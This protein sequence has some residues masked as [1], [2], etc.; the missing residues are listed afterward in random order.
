MGEANVMENVVHGAATNEVECLWEKGVS[1][2]KTGTDRTKVGQKSSVLNNGVRRWRVSNGTWNGALDLASPGTGGGAGGVG[3]MVESVRG[4]VIL[5]FE[6]A[7]G[8]NGRFLSPLY[9]L[10]VFSLLNDGAYGLNC[11]HRRRKPADG[12]SN[13]AHSV[14][15]R[16][17]LTGE[18]LLVR[19]RVSGAENVGCEIACGR[20]FERTGNKCRGLGPFDLFKHF[21]RCGGVA[22]INNNTTAGAWVTKMDDVNIGGGQTPGNT[23]VRDMQCMVPG[24]P[25]DCNCEGPVIGGAGDDGDKDRGD[26][27]GQ[28][29]FYPCLLYTSPSPRDRQKSRMPSSA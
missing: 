15:F 6:I 13:D 17:L 9:C 2:R 16:P 14:F 1:A 26:K 4:C 5:T 3:V 22:K 23:V 11:I 20:T 29:K 21:K 28:G 12:V 7:R 19:G 10:G 25:H 24:H 27:E 8:K 18:D